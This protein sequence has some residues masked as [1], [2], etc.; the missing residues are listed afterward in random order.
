LA[1]ILG[2]FSTYSF[3]RIVEP[4]KTSQGSALSAQDQASSSPGTF[5]K[6]IRAQPVFLVYC[7]TSAIWNFSLN[8][9]GPFFAPYQ[10]KVLGASATMV[11]IL[12]IASQVTSLV[13]QTPFGALSDRIGPRR[14]VLITG[15]VI[16]VLPI[17]WLFIQEAWQAI[18]VNLVGGALWAGYSLASFNFLLMLTPD[19]QRARYSA[20]YQ[21]V[22]ALSLSAGAMIGSYVV[23]Q[24][25]Y[26]AVFGASGVGRLI[27]AILFARFVHPVE[28]ESIIHGN[29]QES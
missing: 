5:L 11:G 18:P 16:P 26:F 14:V 20:I 12:T 23:T 15:L 21:I 19:E 8:I 24:W 10:V 7:L 22:V 4:A 28:V 29:A 1:L 17:A 27:A 6:G 9:S 2:V 13:S 3:S 25:G